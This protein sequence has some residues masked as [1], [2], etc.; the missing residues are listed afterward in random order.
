MGK[1]SSTFSKSDFDSYRNTYVGFIFQEYNILSEF[2]I[3]DNLSLALELQGKKKDKEKVDYLLKQVDLDGFAKRKPN[4]LSGGQKQRIAIARALIKDPKIIMAD[5][6]TG[7]LDS[8]TG[9]QVFDT[10]KKLSKDHLVI[11]VSHDREFSEIYGDRIIELKDGKILS[12]ETKE[13]I[14]AKVINENIE[15]VG[16]NTLSIKNSKNLRNKDI[17]E[18]I[19]FINENEGQI[20]ISKDN[21]DI[22]S[23]KK[24]NRIDESN[25]TEKFLATKDESIKTKEYNE[26]DAKLIKSKMPMSKAAKMGISSLKV[27]PFRL[28]LTVLLTVTSFILFGVA[29]SL[30]NFD[31]A[32][33]L[34]NSFNT[35]EYD[36]ICLDKKYEIQK[37]YYYNDK[38]SSS[39]TTNDRTYFT[40]EEINYFN[41]KYGNNVLP[42]YY[43][44]NSEIS[45]KNTSAKST[46]PATLTTYT[47][48][49][50]AYANENSKYRNLLY[51]TYPTL[52][53][54][55]AISE[56]YAKLLLANNITDPE[57]NETIK[58]DSP[59]DLINKE[60]YFRD[61]E[62]P[63]TI[64]AIF[65]GSVFP[66][67]FANYDNKVT[68]DGW[69]TQ[70]RYKFTNYLNDSYDKVILVSDKFY[71]NF[72]VTPYISESDTKKDYIEC[73]YYQIE[74]NDRNIYNSGYKLLSDKN[75]EIIYLD[76]E[77]TSDYIIV[78]FNN[79]A[80]L[81]SSDKLSLDDDFWTDDI[82]EKLTEYAYK[83]WLASRQEYLKA[84]YKA[85][86]A[87]ENEYFKNTYEAYYYLDAKLS[88][89][90]FDSTKNQAQIEQLQESET[91]KEF[92]NRS[93]NSKYNDF[94]NHASFD[95]NDALYFDEQ[96][97]YNFYSGAIYSNY[98][99]IHSI[100]SLNNKDVIDSN[101]KEFITSIINYFIK[102]IDL[103]LNVNIKIYNDTTLTI[104][105][106]IAGYY[107][108]NTNNYNDYYIYIN[109]SDAQYF[110]KTSYETSET[111]YKLEDSSSYYLNVY[112]PIKQN[113]NVFAELNNVK[114]NG[115]FY[116]TNNSLYSSINSIVEM[117]NVLKQVFFYV[118]LVLA[119]FAA[120]LL[121][122]F[123]SVSISSKTHEIGVLRAVG[124]RGNDVFKIFFSESLFIAL[125]AFFLALIGAFSI[126]LYLNSYIAQELGLALKLLTFGPLSVSLMLGIAVL[127][128]IIA[129]FIPVY[130]IS[131]KKPVESLRSL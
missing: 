40:Q 62:N 44:G 75:N 118:G 98:F 123:I 116:N 95:N 13:K 7:A 24:A 26:N 73:N 74:A 29:S 124:A 77:A 88:F 30:M 64:K 33:V 8:K 48:K 32:K 109:E 81:I 59:A 119:I 36:E 111:N 99:S 12:D 58:I 120:V 25:K 60:I 127:V 49:G 53:Y 79:L 90:L 115:S 94:L 19:N 22:N 50:F 69:D 130:L 42:I 76:E 6:P 15:I 43:L 65:K 46:T 41:Q 51:G 72:K 96:E 85:H 102:K 91:Y 108:D 67:S 131:R 20:I 104:N 5:E 1:S 28:I 70:T 18:I 39:Y 86:T 71:S 129:T 78:G 38:L 37:K 45:L 66:S 100:R 112:L 4:T 110:K 93:D 27:K 68:V 9:K 126:V 121:F 2:S 47:I 23:F 83:H 128:A 10:L 11:V 97:L 113:S 107:I 31:K 54:D 101:E 61:F 56:Y 17:K 125:L 14:D 84:L 122:N 92:I 106:K 35:S 87:E 63:F 80:T 103:N 82:K 57:T 114:D 21:E 89:L 55:I 105:R 3:E 52:T 117:V 34:N 16:N